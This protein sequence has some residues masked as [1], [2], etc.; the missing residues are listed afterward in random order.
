MCRGALPDFS[1]I[2]SPAFRAATVF[3]GLS[4]VVTV[5]AILLVFRSNWKLKNYSNIYNNTNNNDIDSSLQSSLK[6]YSNFHKLSFINKTR[7]LLKFLL[8]QR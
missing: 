4:V 2:I 5:A 3:S 8:C 7:L 1:S 6:R